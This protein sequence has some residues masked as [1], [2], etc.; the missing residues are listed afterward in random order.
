MNYLFVWIENVFE[1]LKDVAIRLGDI[2]II[3]FSLQT[4]KYYFYFKFFWKINKFSHDNKFAPYIANLFL[5]KLFIKKYNLIKQS[6]E[7]HGILCF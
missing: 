5:M 3:L 7:H 1:Y 2:Q 6:C 4:L